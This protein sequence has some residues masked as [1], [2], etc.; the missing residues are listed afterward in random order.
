MVIGLL[1]ISGI[2]TT[3]GVCEALSAQKKADA[4]AKEKAKF[5]L[6]VTV[7]LDGREPVE[8]WCVLKEGKLWIDHPAFPMPGHKFTGYYFTY[9]SEA[10]HR[11][12]VSTISDDPPMLNW[13][14]VDKDNGM[15]R[16]G[17]R[18]DTLGGHTIGPW[19]WSDDEQW[20][21]LEGDASR[22]AAVQ[23][24]NKK[25]AVVWDRDAGSRREGSE[26]EGGSETEPETEG[27]EDQDGA[28]GERSSRP[29]R[30]VPVMLRR[31]L[32]FGMESRYVKGENG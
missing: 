14:F 5:H 23:M 2:P 18:Q 30:R 29:Q 4:A 8:C 25:W 13:I 31:K 19:Y 9:P 20:L 28:G 15:V 27:T 11:G 10:Q 1:V 3:I 7:S 12:L 21:T 32:Q 6:T 16:H 26:S 22:F 24:E 17:G